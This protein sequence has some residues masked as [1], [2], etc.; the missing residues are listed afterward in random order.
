M[1]PS[2]FHQG[3]GPV[4]HEVPS[5]CMATDRPWSGAVKPTTW[6]SRPRGTLDEATAEDLDGER[7]PEFLLVKQLVTVE[8]RP[9]M[10]ELE[11]E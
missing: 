7:G 11:T 4:F 8:H 6:C 5:H 9:S 3:S 10:S 2:Q 1:F